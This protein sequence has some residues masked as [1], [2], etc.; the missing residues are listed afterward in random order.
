M[1]VPVTFGRLCVGPHVVAFLREH[2]RVTLDMVLS[3]AF[4]DL[5]SERIDVAVRIGVPAEE[6][7]LVVKKLGEHHRFVVASAV[8]FEIAGDELAMQVQFFG[9]LPV[10]AAAS[11]QVRQ[12]AKQSTHE[13]AVRQASRTRWMA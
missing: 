11:E 7:G 1:A 8:P 4:T 5:A 3:D 13:T 6:P 12:T 9:K 2:P 10:G